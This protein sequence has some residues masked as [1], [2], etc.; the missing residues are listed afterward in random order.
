MNW[1]VTRAFQQCGIL[2]RVDSDESVLPSFRLRNTKWFSVSSLTFIEY[3]SDYQRLWSDC[4]Y[5]R[6]GWSEALLFTHTT[7]LEISFWGSIVFQLSMWL[8]LR[9][10]NRLF[11]FMVLLICLFFRVVFYF[12]SLTKWAKHCL[13]QFESKSFNGHQKH[14]Q[15]YIYF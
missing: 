9:S 5:A 10:L 6:A 2:T 15:R 1:A 11:S 7:L 4:A 12:V 14:C 13:E 8:P 3:S